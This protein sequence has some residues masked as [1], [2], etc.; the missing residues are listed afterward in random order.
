[1]SRGTRVCAPIQRE[2][3]TTGCWRQHGGVSVHRDSRERKGNR[4][5][6]A[7]GHMEGTACN[8]VSSCCAPGVS[9]NG[10]SSL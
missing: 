9:G 2:H 3:E 4:E 7:E 8:D 6:V 10:G 5:N 1:M